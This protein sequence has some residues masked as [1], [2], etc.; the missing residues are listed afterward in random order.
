M[1]LDN[2][3]IIKIKD[4]QKFGAIPKWIKRTEWEKSNSHIEINY[5]RK[6]W[7]V[8]KEIFD[9]INRNN[10]PAVDEHQEYEFELDIDDTLSILKQIKENCY[11]AEKWDNSESFWEWNE[12]KRNYKWHLRQAIKITK[13]LK[14]KPIDSY[15]IIFYDSY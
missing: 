7:N 9:Y 14:K 15:Q 4:S 5:W 3:I 1:G 6:C 12:V 11:S 8:R 13:W 10:C 2:G